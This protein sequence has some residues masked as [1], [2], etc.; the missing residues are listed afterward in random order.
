LRP[1]EYTV[2]LKKDARRESKT[3]KVTDKMIN[4]IQLKF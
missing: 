4:T 1:G 3:F 2:L